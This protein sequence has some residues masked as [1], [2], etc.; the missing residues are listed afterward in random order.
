M[1]KHRPDTNGLKDLGRPFSKVKKLQD[2]AK[3]GS[4]FVDFFMRSY[5]AISLTD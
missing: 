5:S 4:F 1:C 3:A 2:P